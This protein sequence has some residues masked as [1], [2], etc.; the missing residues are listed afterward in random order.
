MKNFKEFMIDEDRIYRNNLDEDYE[1]VRSIVED[2]QLN[3]PPGLLEESRR[4]RLRLISVIKSIAIMLKS[5]L[6]TI[7][8]KI[9]NATKTDTKL[10]L[11][12]EQNKI[13]GCLTLLA[14]ASNSSSKSILSKIGSLSALNV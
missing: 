12:A 7:T 9:H 6:A 1:I 2:N 3:I 11:M 4:N 8:K 14:V 5:K 13:I 10:N